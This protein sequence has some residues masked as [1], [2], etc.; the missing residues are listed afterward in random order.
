MSQRPVVVGLLLCEQLIV[1]EK[2]YNVTLVNCFTMRKVDSFPSGPLR[3]TLFAAMTDGQGV[4]QLDVVIRLL[5]DIQTIYWAS[6][7]QSFADPLQEVR[8][9]L[10]ITRCSF[11]SAGPYDVSLFA[12]GELI[13]QHRFHVKSQE[14]QP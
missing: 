3:F 6:M 4:I 10:R 11:P 8:F 1:E 13:G 12:G 14:D 7:T 9:W 2:T 5:E